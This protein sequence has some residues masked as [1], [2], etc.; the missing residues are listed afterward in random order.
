MRP[1]YALIWGQFGL[2][3]SGPVWILN[4]VRCQVNSSRSA[5]LTPGAT[6]SPKGTRGNVRG[7]NSA[8]RRRARDGGIR[9]GTGCGVRAQ[10]RFR[11]RP[12]GRRS[13]A[14]PRRPRYSP[15]PAAPVPL[16]APRLLPLPAARLLG[17]LAP[18]PSPLPPATG[19]VVLGAAGALVTWRDPALRGVL[20]QWSWKDVGVGG[21][22][23]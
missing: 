18:R 14:K 6:G 2:Q 21:V 9:K 8:P 5:G 23:A 3:L 15:P 11:P 1:L 19:Q 17:L 16:R 20:G 7:R 10:L 4:Q 13:S 22:H 12:G